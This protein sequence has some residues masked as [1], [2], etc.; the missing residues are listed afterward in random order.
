MKEMNPDSFIL[1][2]ICFASKYLRH[3]FVLLFTL[4]LLLF[5]RRQSSYKSI[6]QSRDDLYIFQFRIC[7][8][9]FL[10]LLLLRGHV[11]RNSVLAIHQTHTYT[12]TRIAHSLIFDRRR[13]GMMKYYKHPSDDN[14]Q[15]HQKLN[16]FKVIH[17]KSIFLEFYLFI[18]FIYVY[19]CIKIDFLHKFT[20][21][22]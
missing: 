7:F 22:I 4:E 11:L 18:C 9:E 13:R 1:I 3:M 16:I 14:N 17:I 19:V 5:R 2:I 21:R 20:I 8:Y 12:L 6:M 15:Q 10:L